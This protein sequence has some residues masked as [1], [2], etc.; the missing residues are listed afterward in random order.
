MLQ[1]SNTPN[2]LNKKKIRLNKLSGFC[3]LQLRELSTQ[4]QFCNDS[5]VTLDV[6]LLEVFKE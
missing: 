5:T 3:L 2:I 4:A 6:T 1:K